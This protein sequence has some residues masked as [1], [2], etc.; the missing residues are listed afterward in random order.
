[1]R[2]TTPARVE[3]PTYPHVDD[4]DDH[5]ARRRLAGAITQFQETHEM[6]EAAK[7]ALTDLMGVYKLPVIQYK[8][9]RAYW[10]EE[11]RKSTRCAA[12]LDAGVDPEIVAACGSTASRAKLLASCVDPV[13]IESAT[14][15]TSF[16]KCYVERLES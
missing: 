11:T 8:D 5:V 1:M 15:E 3:N 14:T 10:R 13:T 4:L 2:T 9:L 7:A 12:L 6:H 16:V